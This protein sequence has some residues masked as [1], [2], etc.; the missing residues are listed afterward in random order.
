MADAPNVE[1]R[2]RFLELLAV[3]LLDE[4]SSLNEQQREKV[5][6]LLLNREISEEAAWRISR[7][8][9][10]HFQFRKLEDTQNNLDSRLGSLEHRQKENVTFMD[11]VGVKDLIRRFDKELK[12]LRADNTE[13]LL[14]LSENDAFAADS[15][16]RV[17]PA[18]VYILEDDPLAGETLT[19]DLNQ[20]GRS[21]GFDTYF[22]ELPSRG[23]WW[24]KWM[25]RSR[26]RLSRRDVQDR[27]AKV[28][29]A[30]ELKH[31]EHPQSEIDLNLS[32]AA[33][34]IRNTLDGVSEGIVSIGSLF[35]V[36]TTSEGHQK[37]AILSLNRK[38]M[39]ILKAN[40][41]LRT[42]PAEFVRILAERAP[43]ERP[44]ASKTNMA[45]A[46]P[47]AIATGA[48]ENDASSYAFGPAAEGQPPALP[49]PDHKA[50]KT[51]NR[52]TKRK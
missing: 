20:I 49:P 42:D 2:L 24:K 41:L 11:L 6:E 3:L 15:F 30:L 31:L 38:Q 7:N 52:P 32:Q 36:K 1:E 50:S 47:F 46:D 13:I 16:Q 33:L 26:D 18:S 19:R 40:P 25:L 9:L 45:Q 12:G 14:L 39:D 37:I 34:N 21:I 43:E 23:S 8:L 28:E 10:R 22:D 5:R 44:C 27:L 17:V 4:P 48:D 35:G 51:R 29:Q